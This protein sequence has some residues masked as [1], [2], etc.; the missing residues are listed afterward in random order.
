MTYPIN[1]PPPEDPMEIEVITGRKR[2]L[3]FLTMYIHS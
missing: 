3:D 1:E 2:I